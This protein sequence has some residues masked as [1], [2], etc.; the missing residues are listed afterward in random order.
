MS[1]AALHGYGKYNRIRIYQL[2]TCLARTSSTSM[3]CMLVR[4]HH[5]GRHILNFLF[6]GVGDFAVKRCVA[7][8]TVF[9]FTVNKLSTGHANEMEYIESYRINCACE[10]RNCVV[11]ILFWILIPIGLIV[12]FK[13]KENIKSWLEPMKCDHL[14]H[15]FSLIWT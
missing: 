14:N 7:H 3:M 8:F 2:G 11:H 15:W 10:F 1:P 5:H 6:V 13:N 12:L 4:I 9:R